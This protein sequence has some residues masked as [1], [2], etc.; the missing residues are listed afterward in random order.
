MFLGTFFCQSGW[1]GDSFVRVS[2][3]SAVNRFDDTCTFP[4]D[5]DYMPWLILQLY[6][7]GRF[8]LHALANFNF[9]KH[10]Y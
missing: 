8:L 5:F 10:M 3:F 2:V 9:T 4:A 6:A 1:T 7:V